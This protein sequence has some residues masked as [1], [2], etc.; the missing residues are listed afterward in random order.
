M[1]GVSFHVGTGGVCFETYQAS[2][3]NARKVFD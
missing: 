2:M 1:K 3:L